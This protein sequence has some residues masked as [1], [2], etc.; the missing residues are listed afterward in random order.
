G[1]LIATTN[2]EGSLDN[3]LFRRFDD[4]IELPKPSQ[5]EITAILK[6]SFSALK[7]NKTI[8]L[9]QYS[10]ELVGM[11]YAIIVKIANDAAK[12]AIINSCKEISINDLY[13]ALEENKSI[14]R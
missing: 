12:K 4:F 10:K 11:S 2:L 1:I 6:Q 5:N 8:N 7:L 13:S 9:E 3:A 14:N